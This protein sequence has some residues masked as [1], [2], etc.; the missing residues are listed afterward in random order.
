MAPYLT[1]NATDA[2]HYIGLTDRVY[3]FLPLSL[4]DGDLTRIHGPN[5]QISV[6]DYG[7]MLEFYRLLI[8]QLAMPKLKKQSK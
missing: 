4:N 8:Q 5:E 7:Q 1:T 2:R 6:E 3:R